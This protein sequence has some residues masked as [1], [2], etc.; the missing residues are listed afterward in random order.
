MIAFEYLVCLVD[1]FGFE[2]LRVL[3]I[4]GFDYAYLG[5]L[6]V[7]GLRCFCGLL[8]TA[9]YLFVF[10]IVG[11]VDCLEFVCFTFGFSY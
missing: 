6:L 8:L 11:C 3:V 7:Y 4:L 10:L 2:L 5:V 9:G 1:C